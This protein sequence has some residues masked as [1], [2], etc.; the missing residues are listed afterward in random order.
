[1]FFFIVIRLFFSNLQFYIKREKRHIFI[2]R[3]R[4]KMIDCFLSRKGGDGRRMWRLIHFN[5]SAVQTLRHKFFFLLNFHD[6]S[7]NR[8]VVH[9]IQCVTPQ[10]D[11]TARSQC[12]SSSQPVWP[13]FLL[14]IRGLVMWLS[15][16]ELKIKMFP[17]ERR[18]TVSAVMQ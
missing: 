17:T 15:L 18:F 3:L 9:C 16:N 5:F 6:R 2:S 14:T 1:M 10:H 13:L 11:Y 4:L 12:S 8:L 7:S